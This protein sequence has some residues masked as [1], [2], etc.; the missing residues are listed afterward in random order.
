MN[1]FIWPSLTCVYMY[2]FFPVQFS[3]LVCLNV[4]I[5]KSTHWLTLCSAVNTGCLYKVEP[6]GRVE[7]VCASCGITDSQ[8]TVLHQSLSWSHYSPLSIHTYCA[9]HCIHGY[10]HTY[11]VNMTYKCTQYYEGNYFYQ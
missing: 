6:S 10:A 11:T 4:N 8:S 5:C 7:C 3:V 9:S 2:Y 1:I